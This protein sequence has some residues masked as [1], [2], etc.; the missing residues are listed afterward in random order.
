VSGRRAGKGQSFLDIGT[1]SGILAIAAAKLGYQPVESLDLDPDAIRIARANAR[2]N[3]VTKRVRLVCRDLARLPVAVQR[4][5]D[6]ICANLTAD[7]LLAHRNRILSRLEPAG[8]LVLAGTL[9]AQFRAVERAYKESGLKLIARAAE[10]EW[11]S[12]AFVFRG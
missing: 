10:K 1:G 2:R 5:H 11:K 9:R 8:T 7:L 3:R 6:L 12:G 4:K